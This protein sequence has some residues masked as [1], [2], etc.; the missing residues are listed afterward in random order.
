MSTI[1]ETH[2]DHAEGSLL[3][4]Y[5]PLAGLVA[6]VGIAALLFRTGIAN[7][8]AQFG[9]YRLFFQL[10]LAA[11][12]IALL[13]AVLGVR[14]FGLFAPA[15]IA[16]VLLSIGPF[17]GLVVVLNTFL[18]ALAVYFL[19]APFHLGTA[20]RV[21]TLLIS[22]ALAVTTFHVS[23]DYGVLPDFFGDAGLFY[24]TV[25]TAWYADRFGATVE[26]RRWAVPSIRLLWTLVAILFAY[27]LISDAALIAWFMRTPELWPALVVVT[28]VLGQ[29]W[30]FRL[31]EYVRFRSLFERGVVG[32]LAAS[33]RAGQENTEVAADRLRG[34]E[35]AYVD[36]SE[37][38]GMNTR[39]RYIAEYNPPHLR[40]TVDKPRMKRRLNGLDIPAPETYAIITSGREL[41]RAERVLDRHDSFVIK[42]DGSSGGEGIIVVNGRTDD[43]SY[44]T[45]KGPLGRSALLGHIRRITQGHYAG[46]DL[47]G[48]AII[49][50]RITPAPFFRGL[51]GTGVPDIRIVVFQGYPLM[52]MTRLPT[53]ESEGAANLHKGAVGV[54]LSIGEG[55]ALRA[56]HQ[57]HDAF[58]ETHPDTGASL[59]GFVVPDWDRVL[60]TAVRAF[61]A[62]GLGYGGVDVVLDHEGTPRVFEVNV[63]PG[64]GIQNATGTGLLKRLRFVES[65]PTEYEFRPPREKVANAKAWDQQGWEPSLLAEIS[66]A[67]PEAER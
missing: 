48:A 3:R 19:I 15:A 24:P 36:A 59:T 30:R 35:G 50:E 10:A 8:V 22:A 42:P 27:A 61:A 45:S 54:G 6:V 5:V 2:T 25:I 1:Q 52:A 21:A 63:R 58:V 13:R 57:S 60:A 37:V 7:P 39:N 40:T 33:L 16:L 46:F 23:V 38:L 18:V 32:G 56:Y 14:T 66:A 26:E 41:P 53:A 49:E 28:V 43:G 17:W 55:H 34:E 11:F 12:S 51:C 4:E 31:T 29:R 20:F 65:L 62:S 9:E 47:R 67:S 44:D 64:L